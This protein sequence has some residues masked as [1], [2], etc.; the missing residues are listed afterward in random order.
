MARPTEEK[1]FIKLTYVKAQV[2]KCQDLNQTRPQDFPEP[3]LSVK[4]RIISMPVDMFERM[5]EAYD[6]NPKK[7]VDFE[8]LVTC[9]QDQQKYDNDREF[10]R[11]EM[12]EHLLFCDQN[13]LFQIIRFEKM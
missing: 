5:Q 10:L 7:V 8:R 1:V 6:T 13:A 3:K 4:Q 12:G 9:T 11:R 2:Q